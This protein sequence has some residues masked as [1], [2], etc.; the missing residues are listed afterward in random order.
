MK[1]S[2]TKLKESVLS[3]LH[4]LPNTWVTKIQQVAIRGT[5]DIIGCINGYF[6]AIEL[7]TAKGELDPL[8]EYV[9]KQIS[10]AGG[11]GFV[12]T[13]NNWR[14]TFDALRRISEGKEP[15]IH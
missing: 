12:V 11:I 14:S 10:E 4:T 13:P 9:L 2:E 6:V 3:A 5:P 15:D 1:K 8:Q 7:K